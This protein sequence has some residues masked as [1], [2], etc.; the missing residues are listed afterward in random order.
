M[1]FTL[2]SAAEAS[3]LPYEWGV[4]SIFSSIAHQEVFEKLLLLVDSFFYI[5]I[6]HW[7]HLP[8]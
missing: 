3:Y 4:M 8:K 7:E 1:I 5:T 6:S 2:S